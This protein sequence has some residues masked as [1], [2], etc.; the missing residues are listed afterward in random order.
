MPTDELLVAL[1][2]VQAGNHTQ[3]QPESSNTAAVYAF[4]QTIKAVMQDCKA[5]PAE[6][7]P[8]LTDHLASN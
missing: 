6:P 5:L 4:L 7:Y 8:L 3:G 2:H 1:A